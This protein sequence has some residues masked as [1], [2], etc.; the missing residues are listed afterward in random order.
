MFNI[1]ASP[2]AKI[3]LVVLLFTLILA[4]N[5]PTVR[6]QNLV[7]N[8]GFESVNMGSL[9]CSWYVSVSE[10]NSAIN[11]WTMPT[12]G[13][14]DI[15]HTSLSTTCFCSPFSTHSSSPGTQ[16]PR[17]GNS[18]SA[19]FVYGNG[20]CSPY[21]E[22]LQGSLSSA[23]VPGQQYCMEFYVSLADKCIYAVNNIGVYFTTSSFYN[24]SMCVYSVTPQ[25]N[26]TGPIITDKTNWTLISFTFTP[27]S[28]Y[29]HF[30]IGNFYNDV[31]T[32]SINVGGSVAQTRYFIDDVSIQLCNPNPVVTTTGATICQGQ[33][34]TITASS[35]VSGTTFAW[36]TGGTGSSIV[37][38]PTGTTTYTVT[39]TAPS[40][41]TDTETA[42]VTVHPN[43]N[44]T[45]SVSPAAIC[46]GQSATLSAGGASTYVWNPGGLTGA[47]VSVSPS[48]STT[49][50]VTGTSSQGCT[51]T[52]SVNL[53]VNPAPTVTA[54]A[55]PGS[56]CPGQCSNLS[57]S[58][59]G[60]YT[61][62]PGSMSGA[63]VSVCPTVNTTYTVTG[64]QSGC[65][66]TASV[67]V[68]ISP[69]LNITTSTNTPV[70]CPGQCASITA[71][72]GTTYTWIPGGMSGATVSVCPSASTTYT[73]NAS[74]GG[75]CT[76]SSVITITLAP[77]P[78]V[79]LSAN[80]QTICPGQ[81]SLL[82][83]SGASTYT[84]NPGGPGGNTQSVTPSATTTYSVTGTSTQGC[85]ASASVIVNVSANPQILA[86]ASPAGICLGDCSTLTASGAGNYV[87]YPGQQNGSS[88]SVC[89]TSTTTY[90]VA[91][92]LSGC[93]GSATVTVSVGNPPQIQ[94]TAAQPDLCSGQCTLLTLTGAASAVWNPGG[95]QGLQ[96]NVCPQTTTTYT[97]TGSDPA[98]CTS[99]AT[100]TV[101]V[102][103]SPVLNVQA[104]PPSLCSGQCSN[105]SVSGADSYLW[106][107]GD[108]SATLN[109]C[110][111][112]TS[113]YTVTGT[114][115]GCTA[116][117]QLTVSVNSLPGITAT[118]SPDTICPG[119]TVILSATG[120]TSYTWMPGQINGSTLS[121][122]PAQT[123]TYQVTGNDNG[124]TGE[125]WVTVF[126]Y[127]SSSVD[128]ISDKNKGCVPLRVQFMNL[129]NDSTASYL[130]DF[131]DGNT[132]TDPNPVHTYTED[133]LY[134]VS[135]S[136]VPLNGCP[137][138]HVIHQMIRVYPV[139]VADFILNPQMAGIDNPLIS[140]Y[141]HSINATEW[142][143]DFGDAGSTEN[144]STLQNPKHLYSDTGTFII[145]LVASSTGCYDTARNTV[146]IQPDVA[147]F[148]PNAF[149]PNGDGINSY[150]TIIGEGIDESTFRMRVFN[151]WGEQIFFADRSH[152][153][154]DGTYRDKDVEPGVYVYLID[155]VDVNRNEHHYK[156]I[157]NLIR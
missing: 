12:G 99:T 92:D 37:V 7:N 150:F 100:L 130:W 152:P 58:G 145:T 26:Y 36:S 120:A 136:V 113:Q 143:W 133:G 61:W 68:S 121:I 41:G 52:A 149:T 108:T 98:G 129:F 110:P 74:S 147:V 132:S 101:N 127:P 54:T 27:S 10:F 53:V 112:S 71:A 34:A 78:A 43:P 123:T 39:G 153:G 82:T 146:V 42:T 40:G 11:G 125:A 18:M 119:E 114:S 70:V 59:A 86:T 155:F 51:A 142:F 32:S 96:V 4:G 30:T 38:S 103:P 94:A 79:S 139:P 95:L 76:G 90:T 65:T 13:S 88:I 57:A 21:R 135:I 105:L 157:I 138:S 62:M 33:T 24:S 154:W 156:G 148:I 93:T 25:L 16:A 48:A 131:G 6:S 46:A 50:T 84:W 23:L 107:T 116:T 2:R 83:A 3:K 19:M 140:F 69:S 118:A 97:V 72:G 75:G 151:R 144:Y 28:A 5:P 9:L 111:Q 64:T 117:A 73:V 128:F 49:Y 45:A 55:S 85:T 126:V 47:S 89:P 56:V 104:S 109:V 122:Q 63:T 31:A 77:N 106:S 102:N 14:T 17:T 87:W 66:G 8:P 22:Y 137:A 124:C 67:T 35:N 141:D 20:G 29:T 134:D 80:P 91:G 44:V 60:T 1:S 15:F 115:Q 81:S